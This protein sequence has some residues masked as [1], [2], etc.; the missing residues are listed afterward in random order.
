M[1]VVVVVDVVVRVVL[2]VVAEVV[3]SALDVVGNSVVVEKSVPALEIQPIGQLLDQ[4]KAVG[5]HLIAN[6]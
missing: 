5:R 3:P 4:T 6:G 1:V 2:V